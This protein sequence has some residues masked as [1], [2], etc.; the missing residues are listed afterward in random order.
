MKRPPNI[1]FIMTDEQRYDSVGANGNAVIRTPAMDA[2]ANES[3]N[4]SHCFVQAPVC[5]P[6][7]QTIFTSR[8]P[9]SHRNRVN[10]TPMLAGERLLQAYLQD[11]GYATAC[12]GKLHYYP[13]TPEY[14][15]STGFDHVLL[16][17]AAHT[18]AQSDYV[19][20]LR[21]R[22]PALA[23]AYRDTITE[24]GRNPFTARI[25]DELH[26]TTWCGHETRNTLRELANSD[27]P[28]FLFSSYWKPH[29]PF[30]VPEPWASMYDQAQIDTPT[31]LT[32]EQ[33]RA[34]PLPVQKVIRRAL[35]AKWQPDQTLIQWAYRAYYGAIS[36]IDREVGLT[37]AALN[38]LGLTDQTLVV[39]CSDHGDDM[40]EHNYRAKSLFFDASIHIP[41]M[42]SW[43]GVI[44][45]GPYDDLIETTDLMPTLFE[46]CELEPP[47]RMQGRSFARH[48]APPEPPASP[49]FPESG[50]D[51]EPRHFVFAENIIP[52]VITDAALQLDHPY[53]P[54]Q[55]INGIR[56]P[57][58]K[59]V[60]SRRWKYNYYPGNG[61]ELYDL[62]TDPREVNN[63][64]A[65]P[66]HRQRVQDMRQALLDWLITADE[67]DQIAPRWCPV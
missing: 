44:Q 29:P 7:R 22:D 59:M 28:F 35:P 61:E 54:G 17:D 33:V 49:A 52:D 50:S 32:E 66:E 24:P 53:V 62:E 6:S 2:L 37:L 19:R 67:T 1:L 30:E 3:A 56:H 10:Y 27:Q 38:E 20:W 41:M 18:D 13:P 51:Y 42:L 58:A 26:E 40:W 47:P 16:H 8:Y 60:R 15:R 46:L 5:V 12:V 9:H 55:G 57:D 45:P 64:A 25:A 31:P 34:Y 23:E 11:A 36:Q 48:I 4:L 43:P 39:F 21:S 14:A 65:Q 63:L